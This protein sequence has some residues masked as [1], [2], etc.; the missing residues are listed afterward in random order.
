MSYKSEVNG[1]EPKFS[2]KV[3]TRLTHRTANPL[4]WFTLLVWQC[5]ETISRDD[6]LR[7][8]RFHKWFQWFRIGRG[9]ML[10]VA[11]TQVSTSAQRSSHV[12][13]PPVSGNFSSS[14]RSIT[15]VVSIYEANRS[16]KTMGWMAWTRRSCKCDKFVNQNTATCTNQ[17]IL[18]NNS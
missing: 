9:Y 12:S 5:Q 11:S 6:R 17:Q 15:V 14:E 1:E 4:L 10:A 3:K 7:I 2:T 16:P 18:A 8:W 13:V